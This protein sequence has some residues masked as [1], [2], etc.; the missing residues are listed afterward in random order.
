MILSLIAAMAKNNVIGSNNSLIWHLP[1]DLKH[2]KNIT[3][4][5]TVIM[6]RKTYESIGKPLPNRR[7]IVIT[8]SD[9]FTAEGCEIFYSLQEAVDACLEEEEVFIIGG[10][11]IYKQSLHAADKLYITRIYKEFEGDAHFPEFSLSEWRLLSYYRHHADEKNE[12]EYSFSEYE[13][14]G[15]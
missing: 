14:I 6:G 4:G 11:E 1:A 9:T 2:F 5:H 3:S 13:R 10:A 8:H 12:H 7:N 15:F